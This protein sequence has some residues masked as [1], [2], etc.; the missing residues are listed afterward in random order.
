M[1]RVWV[2]TLVMSIL[3]CTQN[4]SELLE[5]IS[6]LKENV[7]PDI[8]FVKGR[9]KTVIKFLSHVGSITIWKIVFC[10]H[11]MLKIY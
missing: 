9:K 10:L 2:D 8:R 5:N 4:R 7:G 6:I 3:C 1:S 11:Y